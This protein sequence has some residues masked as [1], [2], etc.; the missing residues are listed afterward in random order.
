PPA[1]NTGCGVLNPSTRFLHSRFSLSAHTH[2][3]KIPQ[4]HPVSLKMP[5]ARCIIVEWVTQPT[6]HLAIIQGRDLIPTPIVK[7]RLADLPPNLN[8]VRAHL[9][10]HDPKRGDNNG[11]IMDTGVRYGDEVHVI[12]GHD[13][14]E[15]AV[16]MS[17][18]PAALHAP[19]DG[20][21]YF[22]FDH[23]R[24]HELGPLYLRVEVGFEATCP[25][26]SGTCT[27][28]AMSAEIEVRPKKPELDPEY[29]LL[30]R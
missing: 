11:A 24:I 18:R 27:G 30:W 14:C 13:C 3:H 15:S 20:Y 4:L 6:G 23:V 25:D 5:P 2:T 22:R 26:D 12:T 19:G 16:S 1:R 17:Y 21:V 10:L 29:P 7:A 8:S 28:E 9:S